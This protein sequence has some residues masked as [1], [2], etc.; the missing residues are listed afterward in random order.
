[1]TI[2]EAQSEAPRRGQ[3]VCRCCSALPDDDA[4]K[5]L[6]DWL[7]RGPPTAQVETL[8][9]Q[10]VDAPVADDGGFVVRR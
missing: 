9:W 1:M 4:V 7:R 10:A 5:A 3:L 6:R 2:S 8:E